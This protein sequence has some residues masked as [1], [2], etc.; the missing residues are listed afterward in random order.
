MI[1]QPLLPPPLLLQHHRV[2]VPHQRVLHQRVHL[3]RCLRQRHLQVQLVVRPHLVPA[4]RL[5]HPLH[6]HLVVLVPHL[7]VQVVL[8]VVQVHPPVP[9]VRQAHPAPVQPVLQARQAVR[10][11][12]A[13]RLQ[14]RLVLQ[15]QPVQHPV[16]FQ[17]L[18]QAQVV[19]QVPVV[20]LH[21]QPLQVRLFPWS[22]IYLVRKW[23]G[24]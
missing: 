12:V 17:R 1:T 24:M 15:V 19:V 20:P 23:A 2:Q 9:Q 7:P 10:R 5:V 4:P 16:L 22:L 13:L 14:A 11:L 18:V 3:L 6:R 8:R 21:P